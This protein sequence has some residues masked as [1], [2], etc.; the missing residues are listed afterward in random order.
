MLLFNLRVRILTSGGYLDIRRARVFFFSSRI[1]TQLVPLVHS[2]SL[3][4][5]ETRISPVTVTETALGLLDEDKL[6]SGPSEQEE[7]QEIDPLVR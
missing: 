3:R 4:M 6:E 1:A 7:N 5:T 2:F